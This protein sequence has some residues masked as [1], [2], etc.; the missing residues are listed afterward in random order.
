MNLGSDRLILHLS[1][2]LFET[3]AKFGTYHCNTIHYNS[4]KQLFEVT[5]IADNDVKMKKLDNQW[6]N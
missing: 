1:T 4:G 6:T 2:S 5:L 3:F